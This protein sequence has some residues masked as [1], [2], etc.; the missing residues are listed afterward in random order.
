MQYGTTT[1][2]RSPVFVI[3]FV[4]VSA[5]TSRLCFLNISICFY[6]LT[7]TTIKGQRFPLPFYRGLSEKICKEAKRRNSDCSDNEIPFPSPPLRPQSRHFRE[8]S[9]HFRFMR[10]C[11]KKRNHG[12]P[13]LL[14]L[15]NLWSE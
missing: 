14:F 11:N 4:E 10:K 6:L 7:Q 12:K 3:S 1:F 15:L 2:R 13:W 5:P 8:G 9:S